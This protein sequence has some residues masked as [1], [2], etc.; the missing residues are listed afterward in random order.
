MVCMGLVS[1]RMWV[2]CVCFHE[3]VCVFGQYKY[4]L[5]ILSPGGY[6]CVHLHRILCPACVQAARLQI[7]F[8]GTLCVM[9]L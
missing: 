9:A 2:S 4:I 8:C 1:T 6:L 5:S 7:H 3:C